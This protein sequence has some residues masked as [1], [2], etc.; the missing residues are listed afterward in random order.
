MPGC[1]A[2]PHLWGLLLGATEGFLVF[3]LV[4][5][6]NLDVA[7]ESYYCFGMYVVLLLRLLLLWLLLL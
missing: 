7:F 1:A 5:E 3:K 2:E 6:S 4:F